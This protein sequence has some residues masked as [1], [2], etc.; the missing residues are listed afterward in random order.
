MESSRSSILSTLDDIQYSEGINVF[1]TDVSLLISQLE[2]E[3]LAKLDCL[4]VLKLS[5]FLIV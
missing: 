3:K 5:S 1:C 2:C 4:C